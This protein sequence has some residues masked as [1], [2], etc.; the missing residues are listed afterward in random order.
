MNENLCVI[1]GVRHFFAN[2]LWRIAASHS[3]FDRSPCV[4]R[5]LH[6]CS[7]FI[8]RQEGEDFSQ[9]AAGRNDTRNESCFYEKA[10]AKK[11]LSEQCKRL[12]HF[13]Q[14]RKVCKFFGSTWFCFAGTGL[15]GLIHPFF[16]HGFEFFRQF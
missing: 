14:T 9:P 1:S 11:C 2:L 13:R 15:I 4:G 10:L 5:N 6:R 7:R 8:F 3:H 16:F 12:P